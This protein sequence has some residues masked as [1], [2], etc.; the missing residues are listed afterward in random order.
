MRMRARLLPLVALLVVAPTAPRAQVVWQPASPPLVTADNEL[1]YLGAEPIIWSGDY[2]YPA[3]ALVFFNGNQM[4]RSGSYRG[5]PLYTDATRDA[6][7]VVYVP[8]SGGLMQPYERRRNGD[9]AGTTGNTAPSFPTD[10]GVQGRMRE[11]VAVDIA[12]NPGPPDFARPYDVAPMGDTAP[13]VPAAVM[14]EVVSMAGR[15]ITLAPRS[16]PDKAARPKGLNG[17]WVMFDGR[18]WFV[19]GPAQVYDPS[20]FTER[21]SYHGFPVYTRKGESGPIYIPSVPGL[22]TPYALTRRK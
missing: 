12:Q 16:T 1:W 8:L 17:V 22:V 3:G 9:L 6:I 20:Q 10:I 18:R 5:V 19:A 2:Y 13:R 15:S 4:V 7:S 11:G 21:G 14:E